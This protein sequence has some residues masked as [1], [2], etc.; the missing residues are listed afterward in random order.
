MTPDEELALG[1]LDL[2]VDPP[3]L[4][5]CGQCVGRGRLRYPGTKVENRCPA[6]HGVGV[7]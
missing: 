3:P 4:A 6:C 7:R 5:M 2:E 1:E